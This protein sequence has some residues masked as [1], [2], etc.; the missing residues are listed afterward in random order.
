MVELFSLELLTE[1]ILFRGADSNFF[2][3]ENC[4]RKYRGSLGIDDSLLLCILSLKEALPERPLS[5]LGF[6]L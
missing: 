6:R 3:T 2:N 1:V 5:N 4:F